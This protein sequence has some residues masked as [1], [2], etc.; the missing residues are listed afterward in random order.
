MSFQV[1]IEKLVYG[2]CGLARAEGRVV[3]APFV[4]PGERVTVEPEREQRGLI[5]ARTV[6]IETSGPARVTPDCPWFSRC[7]GC[8]YQHIAYERQLEAKRDILLE[9]LARL[10]RIEWTGPVGV[11]SAE[12]WGYRNR[13]QLH[14]AKSGPRFE[15]GYFEHGSHRLCGI[16]ACPVASP[17]LNRAID[18][19]R[20]IGPDHRFPD[21]LR[22]IE[23]FT[24][25]HDLLLTVLDSGRP[26][27]RRFFEWCASELDHLSAE[28]RLDYTVGQDVFRVS[29][30]SF[31]Q[32]NRFLVS[33]L[34]D[35]ALGDASG[36]LAVDLYAGAGLFSLPLAR[37]FSRVLTVDAGRSEVQD[38]VFNATR[39]GV[40]MEVHHSPADRFLESLSDPVDFLL[41]DPPRAGLGRSVTESLVRLRPRRLTLVSC[42]PSTLARDL[43][44]LLA[45][46]FQIRSLQL[47]DLFPQTFH[48]E[49][50]VE[51]QSG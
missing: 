5:N 33:R 29:S 20:R 42:D 2:G 8:H 12:P 47:V 34:S 36:D 24:N 37:R 14:L 1:D 45:G 28:P 9:T 13:A 18:A 38:L 25:E 11:L 7:G 43:A 21:F 4:L 46:G 50:I 40:G 41:A 35:A 23:L 17:A 30:R 51:L 39:A 31:F 44:L 10:G 16:D 15:I 26:I 3:L 32:T 27:G 48:I 19:L 6:R 22:S 49:S